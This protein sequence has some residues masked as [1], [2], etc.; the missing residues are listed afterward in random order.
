M[1]LNREKEV[2]LVLVT[3]SADIA[4]L[5]E[6]NYRL[7]NGRLLELGASDKDL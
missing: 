3:H 2:T 5:M 4:S 1:Q 7:E 6:K